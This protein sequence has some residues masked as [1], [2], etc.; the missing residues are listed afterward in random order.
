VK[1]AAE[2]D[3]IRDLDA[4]FATAGFELRD[5]VD[6]LIVGGGALA[7]ADLKRAFSSAAVKS[8]FT[9]KSADALYEANAR[10]INAELVANFVAGGGE[11]HRALFERTR[12]CI[13][14][15]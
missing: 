11:E 1:A 9:E 3:G 6:A 15:P 4:P 13:A 7:R 10:A 2:K 14:T 12:K 5:R 8:G